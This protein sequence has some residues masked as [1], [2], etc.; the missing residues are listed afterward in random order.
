[1]G[2][3][4][5]RLSLCHL[6]VQQTQAPPLAK[7]YRANTA[8]VVA[9]MNGDLDA[10]EINIVGDGVWGVFKTPLKRDIE[11]LLTVIASINSMIPVLNYKMK[12]KG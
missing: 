5:V 11:D 3:P 1:M 10:R 4:A 9:I 6:I 8:E 2:R 7:I 12:K